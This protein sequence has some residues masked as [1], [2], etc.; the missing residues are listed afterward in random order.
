MGAIFDFL[1]YFF[2]QECQVQIGVEKLSN[3]TVKL[4][5]GEVAIFKPFFTFVAIFFSM[6]FFTYAWKFG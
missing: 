1:I 4:E 5:K 6:T 2:P 3:S